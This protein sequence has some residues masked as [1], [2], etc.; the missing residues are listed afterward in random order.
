MKILL[1]RLSLTNKIKVISYNGVPCLNI[2]LITRLSLVSIYI[3]DTRSDD[4]YTNEIKD[5][6]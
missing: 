1:L 2:S 3:M 6:F 5:H 4:V